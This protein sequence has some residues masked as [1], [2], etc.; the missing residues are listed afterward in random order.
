MQCRK[1]SEFEKVRKLQ[2]G[3]NPDQPEEKGQEEETYDKNRPERKD[4]KGRHIP[5][6]KEI[7]EMISSC[8]LNLSL[9]FLKTN[10]WQHAYN[11]S[12]RALVGDEDPPN[13]L[14]DVLTDAQKAKSLYRKCQAGE[15][16]DT[17]TNDSIAV[18]LKKA[19]KFAPNDSDIKKMLVRIEKEIK[20]AQKK[21]DKKLGGFL[22]NKRL[23]DDNGDTTTNA[24]SPDKEKTGLEKTLDACD[25]KIAPGV[26]EA[27]EKM[28]GMD[29]EGNDEQAVE[30]LTTY[31]TRVFII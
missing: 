23:N 2:E 6:Y 26:F 22:K 13:K 14:H 3:G 20:N 19:A 16:L 18:D 12:H 1:F 27:G 17:V 30:F 25:K 8:Y 10:Q 4:D 29:G 28:T 31:V 9:C 15:N 21:A 24:S 7:R 11:S 5:T